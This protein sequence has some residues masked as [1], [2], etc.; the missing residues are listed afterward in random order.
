MVI[1]RIKFILDKQKP[2]HISI[3]DCEIV[4]RRSLKMT[5]TPIPRQ[6]VRF[7][8]MSIYAVMIA[9]NTLKLSDDVEM[10]VDALFTQVGRMVWITL[11]EATVFDHP[12]FV[13]TVNELQDAGVLS[14]A[15][16]VTFSGPETQNHY[17]VNMQF[18]H[19][20]ERIFS[21]LLKDVFIWRMVRER[22]TVHQ[23]PRATRY[24][25][26]IK[27]LRAC[28]SV[29]ARREGVQELF[30]KRVY[31]RRAHPGEVEMLAEKDAHQLHNA[32]NA[33]AKFRPN[34][35]DHTAELI[36]GDTT[37]EDLLQV[38]EMWKS[39][40]VQET[41]P[42]SS[43]SSAS[44]AAA[45]AASG[46][47][48]TDEGIDPSTGERETISQ[49]RRRISSEADQYCD[50]TDVFLCSLATALD[51]CM[52]SDTI[53]FLD[54][55]TETSFPIPED[56][57]HVPVFIYIGGAWHVIHN[58]DFYMCETAIDA[59]ECWIRLLCRG[60]EILDSI[61]HVAPNIEGFFEAYRIIVGEVSPY[62]QSRIQSR[63]TTMNV[64]SISLPSCY[65]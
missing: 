42:S 44:A 17:C 19:E 27:W 52:A 54:F 64:A 51:G 34:V 58:Q 22:T 37:I 35:I 25:D 60:R 40:G 29:E 6:S 15:G 30:E 26:A 3:N 36:E 5:R 20:T 10:Y 46:T 2:E 50:A 18:L 7:L 41:V 39:S 62:E 12:G 31:D 57:V 21:T 8:W 61:A 33:L 38:A 56:K 59:A 28:I 48:N 65:E 45:A 63:L 11:P 53:T 13:T 1:A 43:S 55:F 32:Y 23:T 9:W 14:M 49:R 47:S 4:R 16:K 24:A